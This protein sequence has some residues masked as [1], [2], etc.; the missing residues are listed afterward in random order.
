MSEPSKRAAGGAVRR[1]AAAV[2]VCCCALPAAGCA[3]QTQGATDT[4]TKIQVVAAETVWGDIAQQI[5]G[6]QIALTSI[7]GENGKGGVAGTAEQAAAFQPTAADAKALQ[8]AQVVILNGAG[9]D[10]WVSQALSSNAGIDRLEVNV[11]NQV[12]VTPGQ[13]PY[14]WYDPAYVQ[15]A[16]QQI[17]QDF[18][19]L[20]PKEQSYFQQ[21]ESAFLANAVTADEQ[22]I[23]SIKQK[24]AGTTVATCD[25]LGTE[26]AAQLGLKSVQPKSAADLATAGGKILLCDAEDPGQASQ[27]LLKQ[28][29]VDQIPVATLSAYPEPAGAS[30]QEWQTSQLQSVSQA[31]AQG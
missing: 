8:A 13:N 30:Y 21:Q 3:S 28:A 5:G 6:D 18:A 1:L 19:Q 7:I 27:D 4:G 9:L 11:A 14:L 29:G 22:A 24:Y 12:G 31:L 23:A 26:L 17:A 25:A 15:T 16:A 2:A 10:P 20:R